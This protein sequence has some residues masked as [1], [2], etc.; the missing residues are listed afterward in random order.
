M[1]A[2]K[3]NWKIFVIIN[4]LLLADPENSE[5]KP[6]PSTVLN[7]EGKTF[8]SVEVNECFFYLIIDT[9]ITKIHYYATN[10]TTRQVLLT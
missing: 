2:M 8:V 3:C 7:S 1:T 9:L 5:A 10:T 4:I 6:T